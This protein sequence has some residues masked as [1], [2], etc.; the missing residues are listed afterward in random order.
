MGCMGLHADLTQAETTNHDSLE[1]SG[2]R[3]GR[4]AEKLRSS[5]AQD[6]EA[7]G[8][9]IAGSQKSENGIQVRPTLH[10]I[11]DDQPAQV[12]QGGHGFIEARQ[13]ERVFE[14][15]I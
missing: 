14:I 13:A 7:G 11:N 8:Q 6:E 15:E 4:L 12:M 2:Q 1:S 3:L 5:T 9:R 10:L